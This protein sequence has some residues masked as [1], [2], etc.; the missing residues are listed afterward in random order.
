M[1]LFPC[2]QGGGGS[3]I[4]AATLSVSSPVTIDAGHIGIVATWQR[5]QTGSPET[6][7]TISGTQDVDYEIILTDDTSQPVTGQ[8]T[9]QSFKTR[10]I[11]AINN[12]TITADHSGGTN[13][14]G[15]GILIYDLS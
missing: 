6:S 7:I 12:I 2:L 10:V 15:G 3:A 14:I 1:A 8:I 11:K 13:Y 5:G 9:V 4:T